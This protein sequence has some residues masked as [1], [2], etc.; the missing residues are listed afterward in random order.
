MTAG[1]NSG[2]CV[3]RGRRAAHAFWVELD[4]GCYSV[5]PFF[6]EKWEGDERTCQRSSSELPKLL[7]GQ[8]SPKL[9]G[10]RQLGL[11]Q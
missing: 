3:R 6:A 10:C 4:H 11:T 7:A 8:V 5:R 9:A 2:L 1:R